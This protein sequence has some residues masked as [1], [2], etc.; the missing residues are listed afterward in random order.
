MVEG[1]PGRRPYRGMGTEAARQAFLHGDGSGSRVV[2]TARLA[3]IGGVHESTIWR[4]LPAWEKEYEAILI[5]TNSSG[6][7]LSVSQE[8]LRQHR[9]HVDFLKAQADILATEVRELP[10]LIAELRGLLNDLKAAEEWDRAASA[11]QIWLKMHGSRRETTK[12]FLAVQQ[13]LSRHSGIDQLEEIALTREKTL[14]SGRA[15]LDVSR[16]KGQADAK[17]GAIPVASTAASRD[18]VF[19]GDDSG[20]PD[21]G[22]DMAEVLGL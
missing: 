9:E 8:T 22:V 16:E 19:G 18:A 13:R 17:Q 3:E 14:A 7:G 11:F 12:L 21:E 2:N 1:K 6:F 15:K 5:Q 10:K 20:D 4:H